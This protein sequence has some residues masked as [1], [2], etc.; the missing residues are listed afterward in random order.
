MIKIYF[1]KPATTP[2]SIPHSFEPLNILKE[3]LSPQS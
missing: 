1:G 2:S 3:P